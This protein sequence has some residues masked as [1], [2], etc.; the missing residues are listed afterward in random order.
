MDIVRLYSFN[1]AL[2]LIDPVAGMRQRRVLRRPEGWFSG[3][4]LRTRID[5][6]VCDLHILGSRWNQAPI[7]AA[8]HTL[9]E[10]HAN[11]RHRG[12]WCDVEAVA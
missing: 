5:G 1:V 2:P 7:H 10:R 4:R 8:E 3:N 11:D 12:A 6:A 9:A